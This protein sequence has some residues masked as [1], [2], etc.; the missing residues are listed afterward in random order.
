MICSQAFE[1]VSSVR[2]GGV[3][4]RRVGRAGAARARERRGGGARTRACA[5]PVA[6]AARAP[7]HHPAE[8]HLT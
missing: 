7:R 8:T 3:V 1:W 5:P 2:R 4:R 6:A